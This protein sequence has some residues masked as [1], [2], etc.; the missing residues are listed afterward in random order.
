MSMY[1]HTNNFKEK[2]LI[3]F[4]ALFVIFSFR[5]E[6]KELQSLQTGYVKVLFDASLKS[7]AEEVLYLYPIIKG[8]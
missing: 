1:D 7:A 4:V 6:A 5:A 3:F 8:I 2:S